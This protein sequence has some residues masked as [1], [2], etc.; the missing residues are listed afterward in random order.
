MNYLKIE[1]QND[2]TFLL[3]GSVDSELEIIMENDHA[4]KVVIS[5]NGSENALIPWSTPIRV[6]GTVQVGFRDAAEIH[7]RVV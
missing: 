2:D 5:V 3:H 4:R 1:G 6:S 7:Y